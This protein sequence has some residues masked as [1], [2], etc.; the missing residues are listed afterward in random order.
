[1]PCQQ[2]YGVFNQ[3]VVLVQKKWQLDRWQATS[4]HDI[5]FSGLQSKAA[6][7]YSCRGL[8]RQVVTSQEAN[9]VEIQP[10]TTFKILLSLNVLVDQQKGDPRLWNSA[11]LDGQKL[12]LQTVHIESPNTGSTETLEFVRSCLD[13]CRTHHNTCASG[14]SNP[15]WYPARLVEILQDSMRLIR[16]AETSIQGPYA[17]LSHCW[18]KVNILKLT[19][20]SLPHLQNEIHLSQLPKTFQ[21]AIQ[22]VKSLGLNYIWIDSLCIVQDSR[23]DWE[24]EARTMLKVYQHALCNIAATHS[25]DDLGGLFRN[26]NRAALGSEIIEVNNN[27]A[28]RGNFRRFRLVDEDC[29][30]QEIDDAPLNRR[31]WVT[32]ERM[33]SR[34]IIHFTSDQVFWDCVPAPWKPSLAEVGESAHEDGLQ[35]RLAHSYAPETVEKGLGQWARIVNA[36]SACGLT[37]LGDKLIAILGMAEHLRNELKIE[38]CAGLWRPKMEIQLAWYVKELSN[39]RGPRNDIAPSW[40][41]VS[42]NGAVDL[43]QIDLYEG[44]DIEPLASV[45]EVNLCQEAREPRGEKVIGYLRMWCSLNPVKLQG[46]PDNPRWKGKGA[47]YARWVWVDSPGVMSAERLFFVP[48]FEL[49]T[50]LSLEDTWKVASEIRG[51]L[52]QGIIGKPGTYRR[53]G[54]A[55]LSDRVREDTRTFGEMYE[56]IKSP[57]GK[58]DLPSED[59]ESGRG[60][61]VTLI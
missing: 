61:L 54:H 43:Q 32:Q 11:Y 36:Y 47:D 13:T 14:V 52:V 51:I 31:A 34:R 46:S 38:Y 44:Y 9:K 27:K 40:S 41:W 58:A 53:C 33:L 56:A 1:M 10:E 37:V 15:P 30:T 42:I 55:F 50:P 18:G 16:P 19:E 35:T 25:A 12:G 39:E 29:F 4:E 57:A 48:L 8:L 21:D 22:V 49:Q 26:R 7:C 17:T 2:C 3:P 23:E 28:L 59:Y 6:E 45:T 24:K 5:T 60:H 20:S